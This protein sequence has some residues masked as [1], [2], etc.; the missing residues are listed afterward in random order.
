MMEQRY[1][2]ACVLAR[3]QGLKE[4]A[5]DAVSAFIASFESDDERRAWTLAFLE[6]HPFGETIRREVYEK[7]VLPVLLEG[8]AHDDAYSLYWLAGTK[9]NLR[10]FDDLYRRMGY[11]L[12]VDLLRRAN[13]IAPERDDVR[14]ELLE[15]NLRLVANYV[16][17]DLVWM[18]EC[19]AVRRE[20][21]D[22][23]LEMIEVA[24]TLDATG[25]YKA[26]IDELEHEL[27]CARG[28]VAQS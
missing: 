13:R 17:H 11:P 5:K 1:Y 18:R 26:R 27:R 24:R 23:M 2:D 8:A 3:S 14:R 19:G 6:T 10:T 22:A 21:C 12:E 7:I 25:A 4:A 20:D 9:Q 15:A 16:W 28:A